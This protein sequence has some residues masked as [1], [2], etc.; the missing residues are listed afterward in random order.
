MPSILDSNFKYTPSYD[1]DISRR[2]KGLKPALSDDALNYKRAFHRC[3]HQAY[4]QGLIDDSK[5]MIL[6]NL[7]YQSLD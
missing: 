1:T 3:L 5:M 6:I 7:Y 2:L 4:E